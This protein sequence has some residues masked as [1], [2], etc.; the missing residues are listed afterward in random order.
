MPSEA[1]VTAAAELHIT[2]NWTAITKFD[3]AFGSGSQACA[4]AGTLRHAW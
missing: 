4:G 1:S 3:G 2:A